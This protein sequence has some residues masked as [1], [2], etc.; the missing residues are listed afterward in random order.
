MLPATYSCYVILPFI[1]A[2]PPR[3]LGQEPGLDA[4]NPVRRLNLSILHCA[5]IQVTTFPS[6]HVAA[7]VAA[8]FTLLEAV[9]LAGVVFLCISLSIAV[10]SVLGRYHYAAD[11]IL[12]IAVALVV[13]AAE[14]GIS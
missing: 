4:P 2:L 8:S 6:A 9:P 13:F 5:S 10:A 11:V 3:L 12:G 7:T 1:Q 14:H